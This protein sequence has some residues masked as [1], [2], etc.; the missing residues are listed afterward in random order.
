M[1]ADVV[2][3][4]SNAAASNKIE[5]P[6]LRSLYCSLAVAFSRRRSLLLVDL[7]SQVRLDELPWAKQILCGL[8]AGSSS[9]SDV[10]ATIDTIR[11]ATR[12]WIDHFPHTMTPNRFV[13]SIK[14]VMRGLK[15]TG[16]TAGQPD[17]IEMPK[18]LEELASDIFMGS[19]SS[20]F[21]LSTLQA[22]RSLQG[23]LY[24]RYYN[25]GPIYD[26]LI[27][28][29]G[30]HAARTDGGREGVTAMSGVLL[31]ATTN[32]MPRWKVP[33]ETGRGNYTVANGRTLEAVM[34]MSTH[35]LCQLYAWLGL[36]NASPSEGGVDN[37]AAVRKTW[38]HIVGLFESPP[39]DT[40]YGYRM[41]AYAWRQLL[42]FLSMEEKRL[43]HA[44]DADS[45]AAFRATM[46]A[47]CD[48]MQQTI[49]TAKLTEVI[50]ERL[51]T[52]F[53]NVLRKVAAEG[54]VNT[55]DDIQK[56]DAEKGCSHGDVV[57][58]YFSWSMFK[59]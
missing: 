28:Q 9:S 7:S 31:E 22:A 14:A 29:L 23:T 18:L 56:P 55:M 26:D 45:I 38:K 43:T 58:G 53:V 48:E 36:G 8:Q 4:L 13:S 32:C 19:F 12:S 21:S 1:I 3:M 5:D 50:S 51:S 25:I 46:A 41:V 2:P 6:I 42:F 37:M 16:S 34:V 59:E 20:N 49:G 17:A 15:G 52:K 30:P 27:A 57:L 47:L 35:N 33:V 54:K 44:D 11:I 39:E 24:E 10:V 40:Y